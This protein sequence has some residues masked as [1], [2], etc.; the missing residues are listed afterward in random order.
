MSESFDVCQTTFMACLIVCI[1]Q[2]TS[3]MGLCSSSKGHLCTRTACACGFM[4]TAAPVTDYKS[5]TAEHQTA[6]LWI[7][8]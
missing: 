4:S 2:V 7:L 8:A 3:L 1:G 6:H 5:V